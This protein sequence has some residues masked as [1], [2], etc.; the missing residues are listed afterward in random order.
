M[1]NNKKYIFI[2]AI[3]FLFVATFFLIEYRKKNIKIGN[4]KRFEYYYNK[5]NAI[6]SNA[7][8]LVECESLCHVV[9]KFYEVHDSYEIDID[10]KELAKLHKILIDYNINKWNGFNKNDKRVLDGNA[11]DLYVLDDKGQ[12]I[13]ASGYMRYPSNYKQVKKEL[14]EFFIHIYKN[15]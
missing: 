1:K 7:H 11:F 12:R 13:Q 8:Y 14:E 15:S 5:G 3:L 9:I 10:K 6:D 4:I 2:V